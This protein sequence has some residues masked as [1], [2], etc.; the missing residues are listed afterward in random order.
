MEDVAFFV[1]ELAAL[2]QDKDKYMWYV[3]ECLAASCKGGKVIVKKHD[4]IPLYVIHLP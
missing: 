1:E 2:Y 3:T 4:P